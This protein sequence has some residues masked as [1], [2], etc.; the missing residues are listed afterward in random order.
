MKR[1]LI[2][3]MLV[4]TVLSMLFADSHSTAATKGDTY[5]SPEIVAYCESIA[6]EYSICP[7]L[8]ES[9]I[10]HES[11]G[12][13]V[14]TNGN[15]K[16]LMQVYEKYHKGRMK[17]LG[18]S[19]IYDPY[20]NILVGTDYLAE[21]FHENED[22]YLVLMK[23]N[24]VRNAESKWARNEFNVYSMSVVK[25]SAELERIHEERGIK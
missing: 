7:E 11:G 21:L 4:V 8:L 10:E 16:G 5:L 12:N 18:V 3:W 23:Y 19:N 9:I 24:G 15:C 2:S 1:K 14:A 17:R 20:G 6:E 22:I 25:R 13:H